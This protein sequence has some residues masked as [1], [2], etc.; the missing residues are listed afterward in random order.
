MVTRRTFALIAAVSL[1]A[2]LL[3]VAP[4]AAAVPTDTA[5]NNRMNDSIRKL[6]ECVKVE[7]VLEHE[8]AL[9]AIAD[10]ND[11]TRA[12][13]TS[14]YADSI[15]YVEGR[16]NAAGYVTSRQEFSFHKF[17]D[18]GGS[19]LQQTAPGSVSYVENTDFGATPHSEPGDVTVTRRMR[20]NWSVMTNFLYNWDHDRGFAQ[21][22]N[23][24]RYNDTTATLWAF[25]VVGSYR[26][27]WGFVISPSLRHQSGDP[28]ARIVQATSGV[29]QATGLTRSLNLTLNYDTE[30]PTAYRE[31]N[32]TIFDMRVE[33][34]FRVPNLKSHELGLFF[35][36]FNITNSNASQSADNTVGRRTVT[37]SSGERVEYARFLRP[38]GVL[39]PRIY[40]LG[41]KYSF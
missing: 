14:G 6:L 25:K 30:G 37:L 15:D 34:R 16:L 10:E 24:D 23:Q 40:R 29:D 39:S 12:S 17:E 19:I 31:D 18:L 13:G 2:S 20:N 22:P 8:K 5:C 41:L 21:N 11:D 35:D 1:G 28:L 36:V 9:Q 27:K 7:G 32:I 38:T 3:W 4:A 33:K 26:A